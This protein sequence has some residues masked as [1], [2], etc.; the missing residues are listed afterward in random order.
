MKELYK[1]QKNKNN[2]S[3][4]QNTFIQIRSFIQ[5][6]KAQIRYDLY[7]GFEELILKKHLKIYRI[8]L[9]EVRKCGFEMKQIMKA[10]KDR[11]SEKHL[12]NNTE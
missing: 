6:C 9:R 2:N 10:L 4:P 7:K 11:D 12:L 8:L 1:L 3:N 5:N